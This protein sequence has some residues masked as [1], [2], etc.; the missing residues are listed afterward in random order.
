MQFTTILVAT[1][2]LFAG[3]AFAKDKASLPLPY[4]KNL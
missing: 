4:S 1:M 2:A 3:A